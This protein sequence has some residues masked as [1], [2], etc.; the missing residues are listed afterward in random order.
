MLL[1]VRGV[2]KGYLCP[3]SLLLVHY[4]TVP[5]LSLRGMR[6]VTLR[7]STVLYIQYP[8][9]YSSKVYTVHTAVRT[10]TVRMYVQTDRDEEM[11]SQTLEDLN[12][13]M[14]C[15]RTYAS[16]SEGSSYDRAEMEK[17]EFPFWDYIL[18]GVCPLKT[19]IVIPVWSMI[20]TSVRCT[21]QRLQLKNTF[22]ICTS[23]V[24]L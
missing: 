19:R 5:S 1:I 18:F 14:Y 20:R 8:G 10:Y 11:T 4:T 23:F 9:M 17:T 13:N 16:P 7:T 21:K 6:T 2:K 22:I 12:Y 24:I 15:A 3:R